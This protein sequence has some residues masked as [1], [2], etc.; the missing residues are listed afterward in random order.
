MKNMQEAYL[1]IFFS[2]HHKDCVEEFKNFRDIIPP[3]C[4][5]NTHFTRGSRSTHLLAEHTVFFLNNP[6]EY[7]EFV[8]RGYF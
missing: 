7:L 3:H 6:T 1:V 2:K 5:D 8:T 4:I